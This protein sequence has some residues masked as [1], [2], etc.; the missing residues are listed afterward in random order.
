MASSRVIPFGKA[1][2]CCL[3][4]YFRYPNVR[5]SKI[6][7]LHHTFFFIN[8]NYTVINGADSMEIYMR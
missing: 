4:Y 3:F 5:L 8:T 6:S 7:F 1:R 2:S